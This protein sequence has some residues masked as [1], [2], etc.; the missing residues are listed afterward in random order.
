MLVLQSFDDCIAIVTIADDEYNSVLMMMMT[1]DACCPLYWQSRRTIK[2][3]A[4]PNTNSD[5]ASARRRTRPFAHLCHHSPIYFTTRP[6]AT[7]NTPTWSST[8]CTVTEQFNI[9]NSHRPIGLTTED[10][11][12][13]YCQ[14]RVLNWKSA[15]SSSREI[16]Q[17]VSSI[18]LGTPLPR[19]R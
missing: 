3:K 6:H 10:T 16:E 5:E 13:I 19:A 2:V 15:F 12:N 14:V 17:A 1:Q 7:R 4:N 8:T 18:S 9:L 11:I